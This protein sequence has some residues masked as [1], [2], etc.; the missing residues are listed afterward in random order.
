MRLDHLQEI[1]QHGMQNGHIHTP[2]ATTGPV[3]VSS[4][5]IPGPRNPSSCSKGRGD[6]G[7]RNQG[8]GQAQKRF[9]EWLRRRVEQGWEAMPGRY[10][11]VEEPSGDW[12]G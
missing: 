5:S 8:Q 3:Q 12:R 4:I 11:L 7:R 1:L 6:G 9:H 10:K 2:G